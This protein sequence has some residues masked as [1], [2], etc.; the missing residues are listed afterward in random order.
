ME[1]VL[2]HPWMLQTDSEYM[3]HLVY[4]QLSKAMENEDLWFEDN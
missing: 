1:E 3:L 2:Q 4:A